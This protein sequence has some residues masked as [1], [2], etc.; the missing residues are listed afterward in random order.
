VLGEAAAVGAI[1]SLLGLGLGILLGQGAVRLVTQTINDL[2][3]VVTVRGVAIE[4]SS[5]VKGAALGMLATLVSAALPAWEAATVPP[6][7]ALT[8]SG[9]EEKARRAVPLTAA[10]GALAL[11][12]GGGL[13]AIPTRDLVI[14]FAG[15]FCVTIGF[16]LLTRL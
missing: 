9:L 12:L 14:S 6:R 16:A 5:L 4:T 8:R 1:G 15:I 11:A 7:L 13:L 3:F 2:Y 10:A